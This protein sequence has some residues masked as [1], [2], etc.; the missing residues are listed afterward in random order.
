MQANQLNRLIKDSQELG[1]YVQKLSK[2]GRNDLAYKIKRK[3]QYLD[4]YITEIQSDQ[5]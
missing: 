1:H 3:Q 4:S 2:K 5:K